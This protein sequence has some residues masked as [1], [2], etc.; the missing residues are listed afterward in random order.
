MKENICPKKIIV[1]AGPTASGKSA[2]AIELARRLKSEII[3]CDSMQIYKGM[4]IG[5]AKP[6]KE[7]MAEI[8]HSMIDVVDPSENFSCSDYAAMATPII[9]RVIGEGKVP[10]I[11]GGTGLYI[12][13]LLGGG[14]PE[15]D[16]LP[17]I[18]TQ[19]LTQAEERGAYDLWLRLAAI[20]RKSASSIHPNN[21]KRVARAIEIFISTGKPKSEWDSQTQLAP[22]RYDPVIMV[23]ERDRNE[24]C[25]RIDCRVDQM[26]ENGLLEEVTGLVSSG[27]LHRGTTASQAIG[28]KELLD[29]LYKE[30]TLKDAVLKIKQATRQY[31]KRQ[32]TWF[33]RY[34][35]AN[36]IPC[37][38]N[39]EDIVNNALNLLTNS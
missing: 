14:Y 31:A 36:P 6:S 11:C 12:D 15:T 10:I 39:F 9:D 22:K 19:L 29:Y 13:A 2:L 30:T 24:L 25:R 26:M 4:D 28:Y 8:R 38:E 27:K 34:K 37:G 17:E 21:V 23:L 16:T 5:T 1:I 35:N 7:E 3:S 18:R 33:R 20:D 32:M